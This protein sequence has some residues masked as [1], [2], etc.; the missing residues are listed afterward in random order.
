[1]HVKDGLV[2]RSK[3]VVIPVA[4]RVEVLKILHAAHG[5]ET[6]M[7]TRSREVMFWPTMSSDIEVLANSC[8]V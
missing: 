1:M 5:G 7:K 8:E 6:K 3:K 4:K 2:F